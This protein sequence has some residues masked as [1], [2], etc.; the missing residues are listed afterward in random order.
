MTRLYAVSNEGV[1][2]L[3]RIHP[4]CNDK[5]TLRTLGSHKKNPFLLSERSHG[6][7]MTFLSCSR[8]TGIKRVELNYELLKSLADRNP[9]ISF[10]WIHIGD[11]DRMSA[12]KEKTVLTP[13]KNLSVILKGACPNKEVHNTYVSE[14][15]DWVILVSHCEGNPIALS[16]ALSY[17]VPVVT[18]DVPGCREIIDDN[19][20]LVLSANPTPEEFISRIQPYI[21]GE[22]DQ[23][24]LRM[25]AYRRWADCFNASS[26]RADFA[27]ELASLYMALNPQC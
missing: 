24:P 11:G 2:Y 13:C 12:L 14:P 4:S 10:R 16:E 5:I 22:K 19:V 8:V 26:L 18:C 27:K 15:I 7:R 6:N 25:A 9:D 23:S 20:G 1:T 21:T 17:G 3:K